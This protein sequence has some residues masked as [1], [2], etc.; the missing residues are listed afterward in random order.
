MFRKVLFCRRC[1]V[2][3]Q[4]I[5]PDRKI[6]DGVHCPS[7]GTTIGGRVLER[8]LAEQARQLISE[9]LSS[10]LTTFRHVRDGSGEPFYLREVSS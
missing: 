9:E 6:Q 5:E 3:A 10:V 1:E 7:C 2:P 4:P 8:I